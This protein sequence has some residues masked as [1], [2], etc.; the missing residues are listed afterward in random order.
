MPSVVPSVSEPIPTTSNWMQHHRKRT[1]SIR[2]NN[3][4]QEPVESMSSLSTG[5]NNL[6]D[7][8]HHHLMDEKYMI[9]D[10]VP[11]SSCDNNEF[12]MTNGNNQLLAAMPR[13]QKLRYEGDN[14]TPKWVRYTGH[15]KEGYCDSCNPGKWLQLK[16]SAYWYHKQFY[17]GISSVSGKS[18][19]KPLEQRMG[20]GDMI[21]GLCHQCHRFV[22]A[23]NGKKKNNYM[24]WY[25]HAHKCHLY[26][27]PKST[28]K[29]M[30]KLS[31]TTSS[32]PK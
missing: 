16:N 25:R 4:H 30:R 1:K 9:N 18:F 20:K 3:S 29:T 11:G 22:P 12:E 6:D 5:S 27:K 7:V 24:L 19:M 26:D 23:C 8:Q 32:I 15:L 21:E 10:V 28:L 31:I 2:E 13:R 14:Y 17:H